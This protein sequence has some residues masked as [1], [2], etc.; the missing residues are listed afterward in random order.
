MRCQLQNEK[1]ALVKLSSAGKK[2]FG[3]TK[4]K[5]RITVTERPVTLS[6]GYWQ[7][8][9]RDEYWGLML[10][11]ARQALKYPTSPREYGGGEPTQ[12]MPTEDMAVIQGGTFLGKPATL[13]AYVVG[14]MDKW[15]MGEVIG[16]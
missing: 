16:T 6:G 10:S 9:S 7:D 1:S 2:F 14:D 11:G 15:I 8:G 13:S 4:T 3:T 12:V 5:M